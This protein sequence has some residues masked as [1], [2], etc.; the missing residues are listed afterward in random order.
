MPVWSQAAEQPSPLRPQSASWCRELDRKR[1]QLLSPPP[2]AHSPLADAS[3]VLP[4]LWCTCGFSPAPSPRTDEL[5]PSPCSW[6]TPATGIMS[7]VLKEP[8]RC[9]GG[10][11]RIAVPA[12]SRGE[13]KRGEERREVPSW[14]RHRG[15][16]VFWLCFR[17][18]GETLTLK[19]CATGEVTSVSRQGDDGEE[20]KSWGERVPHFSA[21]RPLLQPPPRERP[22]SGRGSLPCACS[23][24]GTGQPGGTSS[25]AE[26]PGK[27]E[28]E[29]QWSE[30]SDSPACRVRWEAAAGHTGQGGEVEEGLSKRGGMDSFP[31]PQSA[32][33][34][35]SS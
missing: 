21:Q 9:V 18:L 34:R 4:E 7:W 35:V 33:G 11:P 12:A 32:P 29:G 25:S 20:G 14:W 1:R 31:S 10:G 27:E 13:G 16:G 19:L 30:A 28:E 3:Q 5:S 2:R 17:F 6:D 15:D 26:V 22:A 8:S 24:S 23:S